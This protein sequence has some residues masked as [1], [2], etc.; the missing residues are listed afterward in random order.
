MTYQLLSSLRLETKS[1]LESVGFPTK[2][3]SVVFAMVAKRYTRPMVEFDPYFRIIQAYNSENFRGS[4]DL[5]QRNIR[6][7]LCISTNI[8]AFLITIVLLLWNCVD[9]FNISSPTISTCIYGTEVFIAYFTLLL[10]NRKLR[11]T[12]EH[13]IAVIQKRSSSNS[14]EIYARIEEKH[15]FITRMLFNIPVVACIMV[16]VIT[17]MQPISY[18][19]FKYPKQDQWT[20]PLAMQ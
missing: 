4:R 6:N 15:A 12:I 19:I 20:L 11:T 8:I 9:R 2:V 5:V 7:I 17:G 14:Y 18:A 16:F 10:N 1:S 13:L 3:F